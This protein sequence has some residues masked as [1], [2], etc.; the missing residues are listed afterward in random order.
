MANPSKDGL[1]PRT[2]Y[3]NERQEL[4][5]FEREGGGRPAVF[6]PINWTAKATSLVNSFRSVTA[7]TSNT[8]DPSTE[9]HHFIIAVPVDAVQKLSKSKKAQAQGGKLS[10]VPT[11]GGEQSR[12]FRKLGI[13]LIETHSGGRA[14]VHVPAADVTRIA[15]TI[16]SLPNAREREKARWISVAEFQAVDWSMR[17]DQEWLDSLDPSKPVA[18]VLR[19]QPTLSRLEVREIIASVANLL[20]QQ[21]QKN[22]RLLKS[23]REF[24][25]RYWCSGIMTTHVIRILASEFT[26]IQSIHPPLSTPLAGFRRPAVPVRLVSTDAW[27][28]SSFPPTANTNLPTVAVVDSGI[29]ENH[30]HLGP[31]RRPGFRRPDLD[32]FF[33]VDGDHGTTVASSVV[34]GHLD[35]TEG[36]P[37]VAPQGYCR[38][39]DVMVSADIKDHIDD[40]VVIPALEAVAGTSP[41]VRVFNMSFGGS[42]LD[43]LPP[44]ARREQL[45]MLQNFEN[46]AFARDILLVIAA[47]NTEGGLIPDKPYPDH[48]DDPR[49]ALGTYASSFNGIV[50]GAFADA[51]G[52]NCVVNQIGAPSPFTRVGPGLC[53]APLPGFSAPGGNCTID[54]K[55]AFGTGVGVTNASGQWE[56]HF[57]TSMAAPLVAREA[58]WAFHQIGR[59]CGINSIPFTGTVKAWLHLTA[60]RPKL[61]GRIEVLAARTLGRGFPKAERLWSPSAYSAVM[62]WQTVLPSAGAVSR[63]QFPVPTSWIQTATAPKL[64]VVASWN[65]PVNAALSES[66][67][68]RKVGIKVRPFG[69]EKAL[70]GGGTAKGGYPLIDRKFDVQTGL[71]SDAGFTV[72]DALWVIEVDYEEIGEYPPAMIITPQQRVGVVIELW[73]ESETPTSPQSAIQSLPISMQMD[74]LGLLRV[75]LQT[76]VTIKQ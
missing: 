75:P 38:V 44:V 4:G 47:G 2:F 10:E 72:T 51:L 33:L 6:V 65:T 26:S 11:F 49:W 34:F 7:P 16:A 8:R 61:Q 12:L 21:A 74:R 70:L 5:G 32:A 41:D 27:A 53:D 29:P 73:D 59:H 25:G 18:A 57:G 43:A 48:I 58:A 63:V 55:K 76:P 1:K 30:V 15:S 64:R 24:S 35:L 42:P 68:C 54:Y 50:C 13:D 66:W 45:A 67:A 31:F 17:V 60:S 52:D 56:D 39:M 62:I 40:E 19:F 37:T 46:H 20:A 9:H 36:F 22:V 28:P 69:G 3:L 23:G 71:L 14:T